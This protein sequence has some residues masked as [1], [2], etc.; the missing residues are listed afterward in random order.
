[1]NTFIY[2]IMCPLYVWIIKNHNKNGVTDVVLLEE[3]IPL[4][5]NNYSDILYNVFIYY[6][7]LQKITYNNQ[8]NYIKISKFRKVYDEL[9]TNISEL[10]PNIV[11]NVYGLPKGMNDSLEQSKERQTY[12]QNLKGI[13]TYKPIQGKFNLNNNSHMKKAYI[14]MNEA[15][16]LQLCVDYNFIPNIITSTQGRCIFH[17]TIKHVNKKP[18]YDTDDLIHSKSHL[19]SSKTSKSFETTLRQHDNKYIKNMSSS[20]T[21]SSTSFSHA[22]PTPAV[23]AHTAAPSLGF[24]EFLEA[25]ARVAVV[26]LAQHVHFDT[27]FPTPYAKVRALLEIY[28]LADIKKLKEI[29]VIRSSALTLSM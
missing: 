13:K 28:G 3:R 19:K 10:I 29:Q 17:E 20:A 15:S 25:V 27:L 8:Y 23:V 18:C 26:G 14:I 9:Q 7:H 1:M 22:Q 5:L 11:E 4:I 6:S 24:S 12:F 21:T 2:E 16:F